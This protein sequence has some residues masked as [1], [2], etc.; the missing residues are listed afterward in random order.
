MSLSQK[1]EDWWFQGAKTHWDEGI[2]NLPRDTCTLCFDGGD[3]GF[4]GTCNF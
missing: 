1:K 2:R 3:G 4:V